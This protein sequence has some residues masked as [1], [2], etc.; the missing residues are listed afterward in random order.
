MKIYALKN[1]KIIATVVGT[2]DTEFYVKSLY[3]GN[4]GEF[5]SWDKD[6]PKWREKPLLIL[7]YVE[8]TRNMSKAE[9]A[10]NFDLTEEQVSDKLYEALT[11]EYTTMVVPYDSVKLIEGEA[12]ENKNTN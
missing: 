5:R 8:K 6:Y 10:F 7:Q 2:Y 11:N 1:D 9:V 3:K 12:C 4:F